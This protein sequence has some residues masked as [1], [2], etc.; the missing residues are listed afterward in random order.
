MGRC[1][2]WSPQGGKVGEGDKEKGTYPFLF[3]LLQG[4]LPLLYIPLYI[5]IHGIHP[6]I[7]CV[8]FLSL[9]VLRKREHEQGQRE[10][11]RETPKQAPHCQHRVQCG[12]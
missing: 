6:C 2:K 5:I 7:F 9:F 4:W 10:R 12:A 11:E 8:I 1:P 3:H